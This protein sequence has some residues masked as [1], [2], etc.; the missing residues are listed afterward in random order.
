MPD[1]PLQ[2]LPLRG[3]R[4]FDMTR[5]LAGPFATA[6][7]ADLGAEIIKLEPPA[8]DDYRHIGPFVQGESALFQLTNRGK[9]SIA[10]DLRQPEGQRLAQDIAATC[11][12]AVENFRP[13]V[14]AKLG[15]DAE[16]LRARRPDMIHASVSGFGQTGPWTGLPAYDLVVQALSGLMAVNGDEGGAPL[17]VGE[18]Y[19]DLMGGLYA[20]WAILAALVRRAA[21]GQGATIDVSMHDAL[22]SLLPTAHAQY[23]YGGREPARTG[24][25]HPLSTPFGCY[26]ARDGLVAICVLNDKHFAAFAALI[27]HPGLPTEARFASDSARTENEPALKALIEGWLA[28]LAADEAVAQLT[29]AGLPCAPIRAFAAAATS[30]QTRDRDLIGTLPHPRLGQVAVVGQPVRFDGAKPL[31]PTAAPGLGQDADA[32]LAA[33]G[34][35]PADIARLKAANI[36]TGDAA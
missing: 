32:I 9:K 22:F 14:A 26:A 20:S 34:L 31:A 16:T 3:L 19:G 12:V 27:G 33:I 25:R 35:A 10:I 13:G 1:L 24:N 21:T 6:L 15:L 18:S 17:K 7:L 5:V 2:G 29:A 8:G 28:P 23:L 4:V 11:D 30:P 36:I